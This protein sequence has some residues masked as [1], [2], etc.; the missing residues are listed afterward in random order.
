MVP[1]G[2]EGGRN[3]GKG[4]EGESRAGDSDFRC[5]EGRVEGRGVEVGVGLDFLGL[6]D[7]GFVGVGGAGFEDESPSSP[8]APVSPSSS[9]EF[10]QAWMRFLPWSRVMM[11]WSL[12]VANV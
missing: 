9:V 3:V 2:R 7:L 1:E 11:G 8:S 12:G 10:K 4:W 5:G 6:E